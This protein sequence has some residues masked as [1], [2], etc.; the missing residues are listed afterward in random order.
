MKEFFKQNKIAIVIVIATVILAAIALF[1]AIRLYQLRNQAVAPTAPESR[2]GAQ[3]CE[4]PEI[5]AKHTGSLDP[6]SEGWTD[7]ANNPANNG[8]TVSIG[9][10]AGDQG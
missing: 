10:I 1:T 5:I 7:D 4:Q 8:Q 3:V 2:P 9:P 6:S